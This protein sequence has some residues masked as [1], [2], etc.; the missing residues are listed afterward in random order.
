MSIPGTGI[1]Y[2]TSSRS[3]KSSAYSR[4][5]ELK[6]LQREQAKMQEL[7]RNKLEVELFE[8]KLDMIKSIHKEC[9]ENIKKK[10]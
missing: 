1:S 8:N 9:D 2:T 6:K 5:S 7:E 4:N 3:Y 10:Y